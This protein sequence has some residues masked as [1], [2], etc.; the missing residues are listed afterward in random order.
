MVEFRTLNYSPM[1]RGY[2]QAIQ[3]IPVERPSVEEPIIPIS[4][5]GTTVPEHDPAGRFKN[6]VQG[7]QAEI[8]K[9]AGTLQLIM[10]TP[11][12]SPMGG[13]PKAY[14]K[15]VRQAIR[16]VALANQVAIKGVEM[17]TAMNNLSGF[18][19]HDARACGKNQVINGECL[20]NHFIQRVQ[21]TSGCN[22]SCKLP[23]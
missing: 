4:E 19:F 18:P 8:R 21:R 10:M 13:R 3:D 2:H 16:E 5:L 9:G 15:E 20:I 1:D 6:I 22:H 23:L 7:I 12:D 11:P 17:P 14:G